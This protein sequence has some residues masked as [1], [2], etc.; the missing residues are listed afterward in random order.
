MVDKIRLDNYI[1]AF[2]F[3]SVDVYFPSQDVRHYYHHAQQTFSKLE[4]RKFKKHAKII[5]LYK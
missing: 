1:F 5:N 3:L 2:L 4:G